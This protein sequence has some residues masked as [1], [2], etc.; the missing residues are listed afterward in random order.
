MKNN[1][2]GVFM[3]NSK[4]QPQKKSSETVLKWVI[5]I[6]AIGISFFGI[7]LALISIYAIPT[8]IPHPLA[9]SIYFLGSVSIVLCLIFFFRR[10]AN[11]E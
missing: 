5:T 8:K 1:V 3:D 9:G 11:K 7:M 2:K 10:K 6:V 4:M